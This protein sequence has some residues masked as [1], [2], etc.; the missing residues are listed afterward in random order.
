M[1]KFPCLRCYPLLQ[2]PKAGVSY[3]VL[4]KTLGLKVHDFR[5]AVLGIPLKLYTDVDW[6]LT[7][8]ANNYLNVDLARDL[9]SINNI[10]LSAAIGYKRILSNKT[11]VTNQFSGGAN[12][13]YRNFGILLGYAHRYQ[14]RSETTMPSTGGLTLKFYQELFSTLELDVSGTYW[15]DDFQY[16]LKIKEDL[17]CSGVI[18]GV[19]FERMADWSELDV[20]VLFRY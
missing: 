18:L 2:E 4:H 6:R 19:G 3:G 1:A 14:R 5:P 12:L 9:T 13:Y 15:F 7:G 10:Y 20:S 8:K 17:F 16:S 11:D